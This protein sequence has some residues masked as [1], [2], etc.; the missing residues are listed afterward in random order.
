MILVETVPDPSRMNCDDIRGYADVYLD[1]E[2][3]GTDRRCF[4]AHLEECDDCRSN[5]EA[6]RLFREHFRSQVRPVKAPEHVHRRVLEGL[7]A[8]AAR[9]TRL[10]RF[11]ETALRYAPVAVA[12]AIA[13]VVMWPDSDAPRVDP[14][15]GAI[16]S[17]VWGGVTSTV[18]PVTSDGTRRTSTLTMS[19]TSDISLDVKGD[20]AAIRAYMADRLPFVPIAPLRT[21]DALELV[22]AR[23]ISSDGHHGV[24]LMYQYG[25]ERIPVVQ[26]PIRPGV[27]S[28]DFRRAG[29]GSVAEVVRAG[30]YSRITSDLDVT[31]LRRLVS[32]H[33][34]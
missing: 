5:I 9:P 26:T 23:V 29:G 24:L 16:Q 19:F 18:V 34:R 3:D 10:E 31:Q 1:D 21:G 2:F 15:V 14:P 32:A 22:G 4:E 12:A 6:E 33:L 28:T 7:A 11:G 27:E 13:A 20:E 30:R 17:S 8:E 25:T